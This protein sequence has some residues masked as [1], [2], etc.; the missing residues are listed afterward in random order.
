MNDSIL[1]QPLSHII[2]E[3]LRQRIWR[4]KIEFGDRLLESDL[5]EDFDVSRSTIREALKILEH[6][7]LVINKA[8]KGTYVTDFSEKDLEE[9]I[10]LRTL[11][12]E[13]AFIQALPH[14]ESKHFSKL[15]YIVDDMRVKAD[16]GNWDDLF[17][18]D[19]KLHGYVV[20]LCGNSRIIKI[21]NSLQV[22]IRTYLVHLDRY[23]SNHQSFY[24]E[25]QDLLQALLT[26]NSQTVKASVRNHIEYVEEKLLGVYQ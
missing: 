4:K 22:Q 24:E 15:K 2:A 14:L 10:E 12:E 13:Q 7:S 3:E 21:Y 17:D 6:E 11:L 9:M 20:S 18:L 26:K 8:R 5:A 1:Q 25:H 19:M 23:Y 16:E